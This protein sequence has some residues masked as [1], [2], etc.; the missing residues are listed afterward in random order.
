MSP[1][2]WPGKETAKGVPKKRCC[3]NPLYHI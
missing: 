3:N 1:A 2:A